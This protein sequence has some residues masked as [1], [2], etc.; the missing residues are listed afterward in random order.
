VCA[1]SLPKAS[2]MVGGDPCIPHL[3]R[4]EPNREA[5][6]D[7]LKPE[8]VPLGFVRPAVSFGWTDGCGGGWINAI[9]AGTA[10]NLE[11][12]AAKI[13]VRCRVPIAGY[14]T[15]HSTVGRVEVN[16]IL[17]PGR[18]VDRKYATRNSCMA[19]RRSSYGYEEL[20]ACGRGELFGPG[21]A[22]L[23]LPPLLML[24]RITHIDGTSGTFGNGQIVAELSVAG[25]VRLDWVFSCHFKG[26]PVM[27]GCLELD[28]LWQILGFFLGWSGA[29]GRTRALGVGEVKLKGMVTPDVECLQYTVDVKS[30][31]PA[32]SNAAIANGLLCADGR[33]V[34]TAEDLR[35]GL[36]EARHEGAPT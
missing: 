23:P 20:L 15:V 21:N 14:L 9:R 32:G 12:N 22:R 36:V 26:D 1:G 7:D 24:D 2:T 19:Q 28:A 4:I 30:A 18:W 29:A 3:A 27:P 13:N 10:L 33:L 11:E 35:V 31:A 34:Y 6:Q 25:N 8:T 16:V 17:A 5:V